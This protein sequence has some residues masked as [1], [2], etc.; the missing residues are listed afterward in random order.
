MCRSHIL[1][2][3]KKRRYK[4]NTLVQ[5]AYRDTLKW[6]HILFVTYKQERCTKCSFPEEAA[7]QV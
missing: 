6:G 2:R 4:E 5:N 7:K 1:G 3:K